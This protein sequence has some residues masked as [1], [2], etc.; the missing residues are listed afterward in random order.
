MHAMRKGTSSN[1]LSISIGDAARETNYDGSK[2][3]F[4]TYILTEKCTTRLRVDCSVCSHHQ[5]N[6]EIVCRFILLF[7]AMKIHDYLSDMSGLLTLLTLF[8]SFLCLSIFLLSMLSFIPTYRSREPDNVAISQPCASA[9]HHTSLLTCTNFIRRRAQCAR[10]VKYKGGR[11]RK[12]R[13]DANV[14]VSFRKRK[15]KLQKAR[16]FA[17]SDA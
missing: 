11:T 10:F 6:P 17:R 5:R 14:S 13:F 2:N 9:S 15:L 16:P 3:N 4:E 12:D 8:I 1:L 7:L